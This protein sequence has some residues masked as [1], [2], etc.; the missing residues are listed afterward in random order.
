MKLT[1]LGALLVASL[2]FGFSTDL[3]DPAVVFNQGRDGATC[4]IN[5]SLSD[6]TFIAGTGNLTLVQKDGEL[7][8]FVCR[9]E[10]SVGSVDRGTQE[11]LTCNATSSGQVTIAPSG[12]F[13]AVCSGKN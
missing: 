13:S 5:G 3:Q 9:G 11:D 12:R 2:S 7:A 1:L 10:L 6:G 8:T 4:A